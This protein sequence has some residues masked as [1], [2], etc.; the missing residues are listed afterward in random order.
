[1]DWSGVSSLL[2]AAGLGRLIGLQSTVCKSM[3][4]H[5][6]QSASECMRR[7]T[8]FCTKDSEMHCALRSFAGPLNSRKRQSP[9]IDSSSIDSISTAPP[10]HNRNFV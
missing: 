3:L 6:Y 5:S 8:E 2:T 4:M 7:R 9:T 1:M 10:H